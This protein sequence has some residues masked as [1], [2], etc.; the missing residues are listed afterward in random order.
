LEKIE[1]GL[2]RNRII[3]NRDGSFFELL[4]YPKKKVEKSSKK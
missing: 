3:V 4:I 1:T 2:G